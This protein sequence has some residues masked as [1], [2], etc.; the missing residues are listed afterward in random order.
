QIYAAQERARRA[1]QSPAPP[2]APPA[3]RR[4]A[5][6]GRS[7]LLPPVLAVAPLPPSPARE[8]GQTSGEDRVFTDEERSAMEAGP[9]VDPDTTFG[10]FYQIGGRNHGIRRWISN[11]FRRRGTLPAQHTG[12]PEHTRAMDARDAEEQAMH[13][14]ALQAELDALGDDSTPRPPSGPPP[15]AS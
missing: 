15:S 14:T 8:R 6:V 10:Q 7:G 1:S 13:D 3:P 2:V 12:G 11:F 9:S 5:P 4:H